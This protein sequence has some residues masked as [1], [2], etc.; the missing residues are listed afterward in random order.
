MEKNPDTAARQGFLHEDFRLFHLRGIP[1]GQYEPHYHDF[2]KILVFL[3]GNINYTIE[4]R[5]YSLLPYDILLVDKGQ[6][7]MP[8][9][10]SQKPYERIILYLSPAL[11]DSGGNAEPLSQCFLEAQYRHSGVLRLEHDTRAPLFSLLRR[12]EEALGDKKEEFAA[13]LLS[14]LLCLEFLILL[15]RICQD[16]ASGFLASGT[17][18]YRISGLLAYIGSHL[19]EDLSIPQLSEVC[20]LSPYH[21]MRLF[22]EQ[23]GST[24]GSYITEKR[25]LLAREQ[26]AQGTSVTNACFSSGFKSYGSFLRAYK[27]RF[28]EAPRRGRKEKL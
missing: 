25:L 11:L 21:M 19:E 17:L 12:L 20:F 5:T 27:K 4:G 18:D 16:P 9:A 24:I 26:M 13:P 22:K 6:I 3:E 28:G 23:T 7:H 2:Y 8:R 1:S 10:L 14:R 15:N